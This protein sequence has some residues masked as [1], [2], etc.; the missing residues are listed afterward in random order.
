[1]SQERC[2]RA[3]LSTAA[4]ALAAS[5]LSGPTAAQVGTR[6]CSPATSN[7]SGLPGQ[8]TAVGSADL[9]L[10]GNQLILVASSLPRNTFGIFVTSRTPDFIP[11]PG[12]SLGTLCLGL[13]LGRY[14]APGQVL[15]TGG[16][17]VIA[18][19]IDL[20]TTPEGAGFTQ[21]VDGDI[22][23]FQAWF[24]D[25]A[26]GG[27]S[28]SNFSDA[29]AVTFTDSGPTG[30]NLVADALSLS[31]W[32]V[33]PGSAV[34]AASLISNQGDSF[35]PGFS[36]GYYLSTDEVIDSSDVLLYERI[37][38]FGLA[39]GVSSIESHPITI[40]AS[41]APGSYRIGVLADNQAIVDEV[42][43]ADN[44]FFATRPL[45]IYDPPPGM[46]LIR[47][48]TFLMGSEAAGGHPYFGQA[49]ERP[50]HVVTISYDYWIDT[51]EV[52]QSSFQAILGTNPSTFQGA[53]LPVE[54]VDWNDA[55]SFCA[56]L[57]ALYSHQL[58]TG[59]EFRLPTEAEW[60]HACRA[61]SASEFHY[62]SDLFCEQACHG[63]SEHS[64]SLCGT[65]STTQTGSYEPNA[66]GLHDM[67]GNVWEW[68]LD[69][70]AAYSDQPVRDPFVG[71]GD[72]RV[73]RG[74][75]WNSYSD[76]CRSAQRQD[77]PVDLRYDD[78]GFR[79]VLGPILTP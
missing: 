24:R 23:H 79:V 59:Y 1:M 25:V 33:Q 5:A 52:S 68:C 63:L 38:P 39:P 29:V 36:V 73:I 76:Y 57:N 17:G 2:G 35:S 53:D 19:Q 11:N 13:P 15:G 56:A 50:V 6:Y 40:P 26:A 20:A 8:I 42:D 65:P 67:H 69:A 12:G 32:L 14:V 75:G 7:A 77:A 30:P 10:N 28:A 49:R 37:V 9:A 34:Q 22:W 51:H 18:L 16:T 78:L 62:G 60:E 3:C 61:G 27:V 74:G 41:V 54:S 31:E 21:V 55:M 72:R 70:P 46:A 64:S 45:V 44:A 71:G 66:F 4:F 47:A 58:P 48:A 43:E